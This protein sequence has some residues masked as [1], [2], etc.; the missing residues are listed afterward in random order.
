VSPFETLGFTVFILV[1]FLGVYAII[2][3]FPGTV[4]IFIDALVFSAATGFSIIEWK[5]LVCI[6][7]IVLSVETADAL[8]G[9]SNTKRPAVSR[10]G[11]VASGAG[12]AIGAVVLTPLLLA[13]GTFLG[14]FLGGL[15]GLFVMQRIEQHTLKP[16]FREPTKAML[17]R[18]AATCGKGTAAMA[19]AVFMLA[20]LYS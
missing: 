5:H 14:M 17:V 13:P 10:A 8:I 9:L 20:R 7:L 18:I 19:M 3:G 4:I 16:V 15:A 2:Y 1:L 12:A 6:A 11:I